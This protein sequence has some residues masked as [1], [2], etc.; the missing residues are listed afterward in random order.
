[1]SAANSRG[2]GPALPSEIIAAANRGWQLLPLCRHDDLSY[3]ERERGKVP[4]RGF[5]EWQKRA[6]SN[7]VQL[8]KWAA[9]FPGCNWAIACGS[10]SGVVVVDVDGPEGR[11]SLAALEG[12]ECPFPQT[13]TVQ[14]GRENGG[15][16]FYYRL[17]EGV[18]VPNNNSGKIG[19]KIDVKSI[20]GYV[21]VPGS[22]HA[23]GKQYRFVDPSVP[24]AELPEWIVERLKG[25]PPKSEQQQVSGEQKI[26]KGK[27]HDTLRDF[28]WKMLR[29]G[30]CA[31][32]VIKAL[33]EVNANQ[34]DPPYSASEMDKKA[35]GYVNDFKP[36]GNG[37][38]PG[39]GF[40][41]VELGKLLSQPVTPVNWI[42]EQRLVTGSVSIVAAKP[43][44]GKSTFARN[45]ALAVARGQDF[46]DTKV[47]RGGVVYLI[48]EER[49]ED[50]TADFRAL[51]ATG[52]ENILIAEAGTVLDVVSLLQDKKPV[53]LVIDP[54]FR[55]V[56][57]KDEKGY[58]EMYNALGPLIDVARETGTHILALH[59]SSKLAKAEAID[60]PIGSTALGGAVSTLLVMRRTEA[61]RTL[62]T[63][64]RIGEDL[65]ETVLNFNQ[66]TKCLSLGG[67][68]EDAE[69][70]DV[71]REILASLSAGHLTE[72]EI[73][74]AVEGR[75]CCK[76]KAIR[77]LT[78]QGKLV[79]SGGGKRSDPYRYAKACT[80]VP[81]PMKNSGDKKPV[82][83][84]GPKQKEGEQKLVP[85]IHPLMGDKCERRSKNRPHRAALAA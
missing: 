38:T 54:L 83:A 79:R 85:D 51:G 66:A 52:E 40:K 28:G 62:Q 42:W 48:L 44:V 55:L 34:C 60:A 6:T 2:K 33:H 39:N 43:K 31:E 67:S 9:E 64:Q 3:P 17:R 20:G 25:R 19:P 61:Y 5:I 84:V 24:L 1:M 71:A 7:F 59:H 27:R 70:Q 36:L 57:V 74:E 46:L 35:A 45:L 75:N 18:D 32:A 65:P 76:R 23:T 82:L 63:V 58:A 69:V 13:L 72:P 49:A 14:T 50:V 80:L 73:N 15:S 21:V 53:L 11:A 78:E 68:R 22:V 30:M 56:S 12:K 4:P 47:K 41:L 10:A 29:A 16:H 8:E 37:V 26:V 81:T 77:E